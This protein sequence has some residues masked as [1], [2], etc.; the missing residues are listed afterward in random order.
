MALSNSVKP[1][2]FPN[3][4]KSRESGST[5]WATSEAKYS[6]GSKRCPGTAIFFY[7]QCLLWN[8]EALFS[9]DMFFM[10]HV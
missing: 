6:D 5:S 4:N 3:E 8:H 1:F 10:L 9:F 2:I 7:Y